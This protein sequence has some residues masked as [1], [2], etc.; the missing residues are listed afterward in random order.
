MPYVNDANETQK[1]LVWLTVS[2][3]HV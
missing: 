3:C 2:S 1:W